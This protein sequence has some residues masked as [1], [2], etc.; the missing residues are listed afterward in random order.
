[1]AEKSQL[2][3][4][5]NDDETG[6]IPLEV[7]SLV[8][9]STLQKWCSGYF[10]T[11]E[12]LEDYKCKVCPMNSDESGQKFFADILELRSPD[13]ARGYVFFTGKSFRNNGQSLSRHLV[14]REYI[15]I[16]RHTVKSFEDTTIPLAGIYWET[17]Q[18]MW[19]R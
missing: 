5:L 6:W 9:I 13:K 3:Q 19:R 1:M 16:G 2:Q 11:N 15:L 14:E 18:E 12:S 8:K 10:N 4:R 7:N 17:G